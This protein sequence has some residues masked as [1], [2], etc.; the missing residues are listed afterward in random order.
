M[1][2]LHPE[3]TATKEAAGSSNN[4]SKMVRCLFPLLRRRP[5]LLPRTSLTNA[6]FFR[7]RTPSSENDPFLFSKSLSFNAD[8]GMML[9]CVVVMID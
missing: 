2:D 5:M 7:P 9:L 3:Q 6:M 8:T 1:Y 4:I